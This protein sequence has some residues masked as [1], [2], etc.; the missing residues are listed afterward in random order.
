MAGYG[1]GQDSWLAL[2]DSTQQ[3]HGIIIQWPVSSWNFDDSQSVEIF[4]SPLPF[5]LQGVPNV[6]VN[7]IYFTGPSNDTSQPTLYFAVSST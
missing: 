5:S 3:D 7:Q 4:G 1:Q 2:T 6:P